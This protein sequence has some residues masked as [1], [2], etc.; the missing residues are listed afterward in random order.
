[1]KPVS[2]V[3]GLCFN[4]N[5]THDFVSSNPVANLVGVG[6]QRY[7]LLI[8]LKMLDFRIERPRCSF[9]SR[10]TASIPREISITTYNSLTKIFRTHIWICI[11]HIHHILAHA[12]RK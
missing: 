8:I 2:K 7:Y 11:V 4:S 3:A 10:N 6:Y 9:L 12:G 1:M 5:H